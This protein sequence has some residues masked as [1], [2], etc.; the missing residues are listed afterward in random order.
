MITVLL[1]CFNV[2][3][4]H[5]TTL[6]ISNCTFRANVEPP[7]ATHFFSNPYILT[8]QR[9]VRILYKGQPTILVISMI[10]RQVLHDAR[11]RQNYSVLKTFMNNISPQ[12]FW[13]FRQS[14]PAYVETG[15]GKYWTQYEYYWHDRMIFSAQNRSWAI[16]AVLF[17]AS[18][19]KGSKASSDA[20][21]F[22]L[23]V[24]PT[25]AEYKLCL[26]MFPKK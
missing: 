1:S 4:H 15:K 21:H 7:F 22:L 17:N 2:L 23:S 26:R 12:Y 6:T 19:L 3:H 11:S 5:Q 24:R 9:Y 25:T 10:P 13:N 20:L 18:T 8:K 16:S 14:H